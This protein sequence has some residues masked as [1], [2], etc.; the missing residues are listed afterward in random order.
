[1]TVVVANR[2]R[3]SAACNGLLVAMSLRD[4]QALWSGEP[5]IAVVEGNHGVAVP[6]LFFLS[7]DAMSDSGSGFAHRVRR[8]VLIP[9][10]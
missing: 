6:L 4:E 8:V 9:A 3:G 10:S 2:Q 7:S 1:M 5:R